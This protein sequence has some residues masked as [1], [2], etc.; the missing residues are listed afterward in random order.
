MKQQTTMKLFLTTMR[1]FYT[2]VWSAAIATIFFTLRYGVES[3]KSSETWKSTLCASLISVI[4]SALS[5]IFEQ[6]VKDKTTLVLRMS[7]LNNK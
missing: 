4:A 1:L 5:S 2:L 3:L 7:G 6:E